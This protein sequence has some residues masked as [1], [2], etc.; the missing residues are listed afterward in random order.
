MA[1]VGSLAS[2][3]GTLASGHRMGIGELTSEEMAFQMLQMQICFIAVRAFV[4]AV[5]ILVRV[6]GWFP[7]SWSWPSRVS[8]QH[9]TATLLAHDMYGLWF[10]VGEHGSM[11]I[12]LGMRCQTHRTDSDILQ[13]VGHGRWCQLHDVRIGRCG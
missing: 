12:E 4:L 2:I 3:C 7:C 8:R 6:G 10:L 9:A 13:A 1:L 11:R 5:G